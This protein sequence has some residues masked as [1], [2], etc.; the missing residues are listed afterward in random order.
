MTIDRTPFRKKQ[1]HVQADKVIESAQSFLPNLW[2]SLSVQWQSLD[3]PLRFSKASST[4]V[5]FLNLFHIAIKFY[6]NELENDQFV[7]TKSSPILDEPKPFILQA[8]NAIE[9]VFIAI[10]LVNAFVLLAMSYKQMV[11]FHQRTEPRFP[12]SEYGDDWDLE[13]KSR[14]AKLV[15]LEIE[16]ELPDGTIVKDQQL[17]WTLNIWSPSGIALAHPR[18][19]LEIVYLVFS[20]TGVYDLFI[21]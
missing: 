9:Y 21:Q 8:I 19:L 15:M 13:K 14:N 10:S 7:A 5:F 18:R 4:I 3:L 20:S 12:D 16:S 6:Q 17:K 2:M 11:L 1:T